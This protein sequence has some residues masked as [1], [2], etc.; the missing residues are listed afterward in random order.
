MLLI[1][2]R[3]GEN[4][5]DSEE[6]RSSLVEGLKN[7][8]EGFDLVGNTIKKG[9]EVSTLIRRA[10]NPNGYRVEL[11]SAAIPVITIGSK[12]SSKSDQRRL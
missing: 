9:L 12:K 8:T 1:F 6:S 5:I 2:G 3:C 10:N 4:K 11:C 7:I